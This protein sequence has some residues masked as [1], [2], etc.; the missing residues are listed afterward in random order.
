MKVIDKHNLLSLPIPIIIFLGILLCFL[1]Y[2]NGQTFY[3][4]T[5]FINDLSK[6]S[7]IAFG[8][9]SNLKDRNS[10]YGSIVEIEYSKLEGSHIKS[11]E[12][13]EG[14]NT[15]YADTYFCNYHSENDSYINL[16]KNECSISK[17][18]SIKY[19]LSVGDVINA[20]VGFSHFE[21]NVK[22]IL[23][24][25]YG[26]SDANIFEYKGMIVL[27]YNSDMFSE[28]SNYSK[29]T[30]S[31][32][33]IF[34]SSDAVIVEKQS[35]INN[36]LLPI[37]YRQ[38]LYL[39]LECAF[40]IVLVECILENNEA[41]DSVLMA[42]YGLRKRQIKNYIFLYSLYKYAVMFIG[43]VTLSSL[44]AAIVFKEAITYVLLSNCILFISTVIVSY[45]R[46]KNYVWRNIKW[47]Y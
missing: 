30:F 45:L 41:T 22:T 29:I 2:F 47:K 44:I 16:L 27:G 46:N 40:V 38:I 19:D 34:Y 21:F 7:Y 8:E 13:M 26:T 10:Y 1:S 25:Y 37:I 14:E 9:T 42:K 15:E 39:V 6:S 23:G 35:I 33:N 17:D 24:N 11:D 28:F 36:Y 12:F 4:A 32:E 5:D 31:D 43:S 20:D 18:L 3:K